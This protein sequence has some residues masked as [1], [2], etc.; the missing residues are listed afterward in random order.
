MSNDTVVIVGIARTPMGA[1]QGVFNDVSATTLGAFAIQGALADAK[2]SPS[3]VSEVFMG[4]VLQAGLGQ[5]P[6]RQ[7]SLEAGIPQGVPTTTINKVCGSGMKAILLASQSLLCGYSDVVV[8]G[9]MENMSRAPYLLPQAR[10]GYRLGHGELNDHMFFDGLQDASSSTLMGHFAEA[11]AKKYELTR[12]DQDDFAL[13]SL[14]RA[15]L[16]T[17]EGWFDREVNPVT[18]TTRKGE[19]VVKEDESLTNAKPEKIPHLRPAFV[20]SGTVTAANSSSIADG[21]AALVLMKKSL[22]LS[23]GVNILAELSG[24]SEHAHEPEWF[25]T[26]PVQAIQKVSQRSNIALSDVDLFEINEAF[27]VVALAAIK[28]LTL[29][30][31]KVNVVGG[32]CALGHPLGA[33]GARIMVTLIAAMERLDKKRGI[34]SLCIGGGEA[35]A[36]AVSRYCSSE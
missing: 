31:E 4:C 35:I 5:A 14:S 13:R 8:A 10:S 17:S 18:I 15:A 22:A 11:T 36:M 3:D 34:A 21:A 7:A 6:A 24:T 33:S 27:S 30:I 26:A 25:T 23:Q 29:D 32:A 19:V 28:D 2:L 20:K 9:G 12:K 16:A 1:M